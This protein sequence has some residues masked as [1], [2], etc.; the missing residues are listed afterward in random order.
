MKNFNDL[1]RAQ[2]GVS[3]IELM[4]GMVLGLFILLAIGSVFIATSDT[5]R[6]QDAMSRIQE[7]TR[8]SFETLGRVIRKAGYRV[9]GSVT[10]V[11]VFTAATIN[12]QVFVA[13]QKVAGNA[14]TLVVRYQGAADGLTRDCLGGVVAANAVVSE[15]LSLA[16]GQLMCQ[17][18]AGGAVALVDG[19]GD[20]QYTYA[21]DTDGNRAANGYFSPAAVTNWTNVVAVRAEVLLVT[22]AD[23][24]T[25]APRA[26]TFNGVTTA[27]ADVT[28]NRMRRVTSTT[29]ALRN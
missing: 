26:Y 2:R 17:V 18:N 14:T 3:L 25:T 5:N 23:S 15:T 9:D 21:E 4:I 8:F 22:D 1:I 24:V 7:S 16:G 11:S 10:A 12:S 20:I 29:F 19:V 13:G 27:A 6:T 28:D